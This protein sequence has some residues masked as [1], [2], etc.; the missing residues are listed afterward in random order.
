MIQETI[1]GNTPS[2]ETNPTQSVSDCVIDMTGCKGYVALQVKAPNTG[3]K[4]VTRQ[5]GAF[6][7]LTPDNGLSYRYNPINVE[8]DCKVYFGA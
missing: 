7:V 5:S 8:G 2:S 1:T 4:D 6:S 3:W